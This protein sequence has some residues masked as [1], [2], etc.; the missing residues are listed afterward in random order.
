MSYFRN[1]L[2]KSGEYLDQFADDKEAQYYA[3][4]VPTEPTVIKQNVVMPE[5]KGQ[6][7]DDL[8]A[9]TQAFEGVGMKGGLNVTRIGELFD[10]QLSEFD[11]IAVTAKNL[12]QQAKENNKDLFNKQRRSVG[13]NSG[14]SVDEAIQ[15]ASEAGFDNLA[16]RFLKRK[17]GELLRPEQVGGG[18]VVLYRLVKEM[19][20]GA[21]KAL[22]IDPANVAELEEAMLKVE[23]LGQIYTYMSASIGGTVS[24]YGRGLSYVSHLDK[25][26]K[27]DKE[28][29][30]KKMDEF[31]RS[32]SPLRDSDPETRVKNIRFHM[33]NL[34]ALNFADRAKYTDLISRTLNRSRNI[35][36]ESYINA[37]LSS[38]VTHTVNM[39]GNG[40]FQASRLLETGVASMIGKARQ[41]VMELAGVKMDPADRVYAVEAKAF[42]HGSLMAQKDALTLAGKTFI[43]GRSGDL[44]SKL[45][46]DESRI[47]IGNTRD[48]SKILQEA[49]EGNWGS[50]FLNSMGV[51][52]TMSGRFLAVEDEYFKVMI[53]RRVQYQEAFKASLLE[54]QQRVD[55][56]IPLKRTE[57]MKKPVFDG[58]GNLI[59]G[60]LSAE[61]YGARVYQRVL[62]EPSK[63]VVKLMEKTALDETFQ[64]PVQGSGFANGANFLINNDVMKVLGL[65]FFKTPTNIFKQTFDR[66]L[67]VFSAPKALMEGR[68]RDFD[69]ALAKVV[70]GWGIGGTMLALA[71]GY[72]G[73]DVIITGT[74]PVTGYQFK[75]IVNKGAN[76]PPSSIGFKMQDGSYKF[77]SFARF[78]PLSMLL[79][80]SADVSNFLSYSDDAEAGEA[81]LNAFTLAVSEYSANIPF[82]QGLSEIGTLL[83]DRHNTGEKKLE[84]IQRF[85]AQRITDASLSASSNLG[86]IGYYFAEEG[87]NYPFVGSNSFHAT[88]ERIQNP[89]A[90]LN[91][92]TNE[93]LASLNTDRLEDV[94]VMIRAVYEVMNKHRSRNALFSN[95][96]YS[97]V[98]FWNEPVRQVSRENL[99]DLDVGFKNLGF[100][101]P[102]EKLAMF[103]PVKIQSGKFTSLDQELIRLAVGGYGKFSNH[104]RKMRG[105]MLTAEEYLD[106]VGFVNTVDSE[107]RMPG[108]ANYKVKEALLPSLTNAIKSKQYLK[109]DNEGKYQ[110]LEDILN[111]RRDGAREKLFSSGRLGSLFARD[112]PDIQ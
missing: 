14:I 79:T 88:L 111:D 77:V 25:F 61:E 83:A 40:A 84:R 5:L 69:E 97:S 75:D 70:V 112:N 29:I 31:I 39:A 53:K 33:K 12:L 41:G 43:T 72:Y 103:N 9:M 74:G 57:D 67:N 58:E 56:G 51:I 106:F 73:D 36:M 76:V 81:L 60:E 71:H 98:N 37:L 107:G 46:I 42:I 44:M 11:S 16:R 26:L 54:I 68:G 99:A 100:K 93:Q 49:S 13:D 27:V 85:L 6:T 90:S 38:P 30:N 104:K 32:Y 1:F 17:P 87:G 86:G 8:L 80:A 94:P 15:L 52:N 96:T 91:M 22:A 59:E 95:Q 66:S 108:E 23:A 28:N 18:M 35:F 4:Q 21:E 110:Y 2:K 45:D 50:F 19:A 65:P 89:D 7:Q 55:V 92:L 62:E 48:I 47:G 102:G 109:L 105:Y 64:S 24:E 82:M 101:I 3:D 10:K 20:Y 63:D 34:V 78:D